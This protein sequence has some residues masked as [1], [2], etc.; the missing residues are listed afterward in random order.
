MSSLSFNGRLQRIPGTLSATVDPSDMRGLDTAGLV[1]S[2][3]Y[4][5]LASGAG[6]KPIAYCPTTRSKRCKVASG[7]ALAAVGASRASST[8]RLRAS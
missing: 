4:L 7:L 2:G 1:T 6:P 5:A 3:S 8:P